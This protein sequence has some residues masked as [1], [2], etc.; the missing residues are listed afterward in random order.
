MK[1]AFLV[2]LS[3]L[4]IAS[5]FFGCKSKNA[6]SSGTSTDTPSHTFT[7]DG[8]CTTPVICTTCGEIITEAKTEHDYAFVDPSFILGGGAYNLKCTNLNNKCTAT[9]EKETNPL[10]IPFGYSV[11]EKTSENGEV[12]ATIT[13]SFQF[14]AGEI[15][16]YAK[17]LSKNYTQKIY[18]EYGIIVYINGTVNSKPINSSGAITD[19]DV[20]KA[21]YTGAGGVNDFS[22]PG[23][24]TSNYDKELIICAYMIFD[25]QVYYIQSNN[26]YTD[27]KE[28]KPIT[29]NKIL[30]KLNE[31]D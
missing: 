13:T 14:N 27:Y 30:E 17:Y 10:L 29:V 24:S 7:D 6:P 25:D 4:F 28:I 26:V 8:D 16:E 9:I 11:N 2:A 3:V 18:Y 5:M 23:I 20:I 1:K 31:A 15:L 21:N 22:I 12:L 19:S